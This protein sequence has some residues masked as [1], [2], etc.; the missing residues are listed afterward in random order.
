MN[1]AHHEIAD[2]FEKRRLEYPLHN[3]VYGAIVER[4]TMME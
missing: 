1:G 3:R 2:C 4:N